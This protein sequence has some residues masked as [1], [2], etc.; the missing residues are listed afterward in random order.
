MKIYVVRRCLILFHYSEDVME[1][2][3]YFILLNE[4]DKYELKNHVMQLVDTGN[5]SRII[6]AMGRIKYFYHLKYFIDDDWIEEC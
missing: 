2:N 4:Q 5:Y 3:E 1:E 6:T